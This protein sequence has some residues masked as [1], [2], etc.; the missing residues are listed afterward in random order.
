[1]LGSPRTINIVAVRN[2]KPKLVKF[3][4]Y[5]FQGMVFRKDRYNHFAIQAAYK[6]ES[7]IGIHYDLVEYMDATL[8]EG[9]AVKGA[10]KFHDHY[11]IVMSW[12]GIGDVSKFE[13]FV[14]N[15][16][17]RKYASE[18]LFG[19]IFTQLKIWKNNLL[20]ADDRRIICSELIALWLK[21]N[22]FNINDSDF[23]DLVETEKFLNRTKV[24]AKYVE[25]RN[26]SNIE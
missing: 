16:E 13:D 17:G 6:V 15:Y 26:A 3:L 11:D 12:D 21:H 10:S 22:G 1:M 8:K 18:Q 14:K 25:V 5:L 9:V 23:Y 24:S 19:Y 2:K 20:G 7:N 4:I